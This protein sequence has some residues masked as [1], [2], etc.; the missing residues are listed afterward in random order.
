MGGQAAAFGAVPVPFPRVPDTR[1]AVT[2]ALAKARSEAD[3]IVTNG[4]ISVGDY[5]FIKAGLVDPGAREGFWKG[6]QKPRGPPG[7][8]PLA[9]QPLFGPPGDTLAGR[10]CLEENLRAAIRTR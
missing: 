10:V 5:D 4:G 2:A 7:L 1:E 6:K 3:V 8:L 9:G